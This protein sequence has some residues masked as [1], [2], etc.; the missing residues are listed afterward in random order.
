MEAN[1]YVELG[2]DWQTD[3]DIAC[4]T[5]DPSDNPSGCNCCYDTWKAELK[6]V[7]REYNKL[8]EQ[9]TQLTQQQ[10]FVAG[11]RDKLKVWRDDL[12]KTN[13]LAKI[14]CDQFK[15]ISSQTEKICTN[16]EKSS[17][18]IEILFCMIR[19]LYE[20]TDLI[21]TMVA[22]INKCIDCLKSDDLP[23]DSGIR[24][25]LALYLLKAEAVIKTRIELI[26]SI[27]AA[28]KMTTVLD[29]GICSEYGFHKVIT[30][31]VDILN[32]DE[33]CSVSVAPVDPCADKSKMDEESLAKC[34]L[35]PIL[36]L[37]V[38]NDSYYAWVKDKYEKDVAE[39][40]KLSDDLV[41]VNKKKEALAACLASLT[42]A[43]KEV[44]P[45]ELCK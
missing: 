31:W 44:D 23:P 24:K 37:P 25:C 30:E 40:N 19:D 39:A 41:E 12:E 7:T 33:K 32:C 6:E 15:V 45:K 18:S 43:I 26:K 13:L 17:R 22:E 14:L 2:T 11:E 3:T 34:A 10:T 9:S 29:E 28:I 21:I 4:C 20:Q 5:T 38:C 16:T 8:S 36:T 1:K 35:K 27:M 42:A